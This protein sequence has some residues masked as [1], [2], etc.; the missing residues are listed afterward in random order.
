MGPNFGLFQRRDNSDTNFWTP[1]LKGETNVWGTN[2]FGY[3]N[4]KKPPSGPMYIHTHT[5]I[6][7]YIEIYTYSKSVEEPVF[8]ASPALEVMFLLCKIYSVMALGMYKASACLDVIASCEPV[9][10]LDSFNK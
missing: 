5:H 3:P 9:V 1:S 8:S 4:F 10:D 7:I 2:G 6:Y